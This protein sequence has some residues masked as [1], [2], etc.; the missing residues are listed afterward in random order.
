MSFFGGWYIEYICKIYDVYGVDDDG[1]DND[2]DDGDDDDDN[3]DE[4]WF[5]NR[6]PGDPRKINWGGSSC[7][8][9]GTEE[10]L[11]FDNCITM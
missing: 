11:T 3:D 8:M 4:I 7:S 2:D 10:V 9:T 5:A 6:R 1:D